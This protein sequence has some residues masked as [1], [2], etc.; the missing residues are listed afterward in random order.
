M[1]DLTKKA[2]MASLRKMFEPDG[3][4]NVCTIDECLKV[5]NAVPNKE[6]YEALKLLHCVHWR[7]MA[8]EMRTEVFKTVIRMLTEYSFDLD[9][10]DD[11]FNNKP[12][13]ILN[14]QIDGMSEANKDGGGRGWKFLKL[15]F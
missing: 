7:D 4:C 1:N 9:V 8:P 5:V 14:Y 2:L 15:G 6:D 13:N 3:Y 12:I 11:I 10:L